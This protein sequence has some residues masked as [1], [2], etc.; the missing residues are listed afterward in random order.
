MTKKDTK[1]TMY[2]RQVLEI[3]KDANPEGVTESEINAD[4]GKL[5]TEVRKI[6]GY[7][8][9][10]GKIHVPCDEMEG[11]GLIVQVLVSHAVGVRMYITPK[12]VGYLKS[13]V[14]YEVGIP[15]A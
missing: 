1:K 5:R 4:N 9:N 13:M 3:L 7:T 6:L 15:A 14:D 8:D 10:Q 12:G 11:E 2:R